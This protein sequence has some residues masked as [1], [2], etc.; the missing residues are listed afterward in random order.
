[1]YS[2]AYLWPVALVLLSIILPWSATSADAETPVKREI[3]ALY[4]SD[5]E[6]SVAVTLTHLNA[7]MPLNHLGYIVNYHDLKDGLPDA[8]E[9]KNAVAVLT[10]FPGALP[11]HEAYFEWLGR[12]TNSTQLRVIILGNIGGPLTTSD[13]ELLQST[14]HR[15]GL[16]LHPRFITNTFTS[17]VVARDSSVVGF[18][19]EPD[20]IPESHLL[21]S[22]YGKD[23][24]VALEYET[25]DG[26]A[27]TRSVAVAT[28]PGGAYAAPG[29]YIY[30]DETLDQSRW[31]IEP[32][33]F[34]K[35]ALGGARFP[36]PDTTTVSGRRLFF[37]HVDGDGWN[38]LT[39]IERYRGRPTISAEVMLHELVEP[40]PDIPVTIGPI[41]RDLLPT[42]SRGREAARVA[43]DLFALPQVEVASHTYSHPFVWE[44]FE[45][46]DR[47]DEL[48]LVLNRASKGSKSLFSQLWSIASSAR[49][50]ST[51]LL[52]TSREAL[53]R[54]DAHEPFS[55]E[56]EVGGAEAITT[57]LAPPGKHVAVYLW[58]GDA[59]PFESIIAATRKAGMRNLNGGSSRFDQTLPS[60]SRIAP[61]SR[62]VGS[63]RQ[64]YA[65]NDNEFTYTD[66]WRGRFNGFAA[67]IETFRRTEEP[68][69]LRPAGLYYHAFS[70]ERS[71]ALDAVRSILNWAR[72]QPVIP[73]KTLQYAAIADGFFSTTIRQLDLLKWS[74]GDRDGLQT[75]RF[76]DAGNLQVDLAASTGVLGATRHAGALY[77][78]LDPVV[79]TAIVALRNGADD[80]A[81]KTL[82]MAKLE[83]ARWQVR[84][85][86]RKDCRLEFLAQGFGDGN[87]VWR[88][89][90]GS[91]RIRVSRAG[92]ELQQTTAAS[93]KNGR[94]H[95][96]LSANA[97]EPATVE[98]ACIEEGRS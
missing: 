12:V 46:Y 94:L 53:P 85:L 48:A 9:I 43:R 45:D 14:F 33:V 98:L 52:A 90:T 42:T 97:V 69:R 73:I 20:P 15:M 26:G 30:S 79:E 35:R 40:Y 76:D 61:I 37:S 84:D 8:R 18:E 36:V 23:A 55:V 29:S 83:E 28:G 44:Y 59:L 51:G 67:L 39:R 78:A 41:A 60:V 93:D 27:L 6:P 77:V 63:Q 16:E 49:A 13:A 72:E 32:F 47:S 3:L 89:P 22:R 62:Q 11:D 88:V 10:M 96:I 54:Y 70:A 92:V 19:R 81:P 68:R 21:V 50:A 24:D 87:F 2:R 80:H 1:M 31:I 64:I 38:N 58:S 82:D 17:R 71:I 74:V 65:I 25:Q 91:Y 7:E 66:L 4:H 75:V 86:R 56:L 34:F 95:F 5:L 57:A